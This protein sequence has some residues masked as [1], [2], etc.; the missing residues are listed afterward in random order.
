MAHAF[1]ALNFFPVRSPEQYLASNR[2][3]SKMRGKNTYRPDHNTALTS[4]KNCEWLLANSRDEQEVVLACEISVLGSAGQRIKPQL[5]QIGVVMP[6][7]RQ[8]SAMVDH[9]RA[10]ILRFTPERAEIPG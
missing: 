7:L 4:R 2:H 1:Y 8:V 6:P 10:S 5:E 3:L 9:W